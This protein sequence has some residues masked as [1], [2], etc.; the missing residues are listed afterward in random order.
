MESISGPRLRFLVTLGGMDQ[1]GIDDAPFGVSHFLSI[2]ACPDCALVTGPDFSD[3]VC[4]GLINSTRLYCW[5]AIHSLNN[6]VI[7]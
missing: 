6:N 2:S 7:G 1:R 5:I 3:N 4:Y